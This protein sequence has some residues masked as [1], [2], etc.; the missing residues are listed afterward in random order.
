MTTTVRLLNLMGDDVAAAAAA[1]DGVE[2]TT[3]PI[4]DPVP[5]GEQ[6]DVLFGGWVGLDIYD[7]LD[8]LGIQWMHLPGTGVDAWPR[9]Q[10]TGRTVTC[11]RGASAIPIA[12][13]VLGS[14]LAFE[15]HFPE[16]WLDDVPEH[17]NLAS[18]GELAGKTVGIVGLGGIGRAVAQRS[19]A[20]DTRVRAVRRNHAQGAPP[21]IE[22]AKDLPDL[23]ATADHLVIAAP[24]TDATAALL[25]AAAFDQ[26]K[27]GVHIVNIARG[28]LV[29]Q[30]ALR[31]A[32]DDGRVGFASLDTV[33][34]EPLP[35]GHWLFEHPKVHLSAHV[36]WSSPVAFDR[37]REI[38]LDNLRRYVAGEPLEGVVDVDEGY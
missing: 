35:A 21:G 30:D 25:D 28:S 36:S 32:L 4:G 9:E 10:L 15:K 5:E 34:P 2:V 24:A 17:W 16:T 7:R 38:F 26:V 31:V 20:F 23:L 18:L 13:F 19:L 29:D 3:L 27:P 14:M 8:E 11:S 6:F 1:I 33:D 37:L 12:E 22:L